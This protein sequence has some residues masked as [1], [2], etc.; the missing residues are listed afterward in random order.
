MPKITKHAEFLDTLRGMVTKEGQTKEGNAGTASGVPCTDTHPEKV[1]ESTEHVNK[2]EQGHPEKNPQDFKQEK[3]KDGPLHG[4]KGEDQTA[5]EKAAE[6]TAC[7]CGKTP[8]VCSK[9]KAAEATPLAGAAQVPDT[10]APAVAKDA[11]NTVSQT[12]AKTAEDNTENLKLA[13]LGEK[14][15]A[16]IKEANEKTASKAG[17]AS[18]VP[19][20]DTKPA[21][22]PASTDHVNKN[23]E[24]RPEHN[25]QEFKQE[26]GKEG[27]LHGQ[28][29]AAVKDVAKTGAAQEDIDKQASFELG[30][31]FC[32]SFLQTKVASQ[33][34]MYKEA[35]RRDFETL[36]AQA[37]DELDKQQKQAQQN[38]YY[39]ANT[40]QARPQTKQAAALYDEQYAEKQAEEAGA[41]AFYGMM[42]QA[43]EEYQAEQIKLAFEQQVAAINAEKDAALKKAAELEAALKDKEASLQKKAE[44]EKRAQEFHTWGNYVVDQVMTRLQSEAAR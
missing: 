36:I 4:K 10:K 21:S 30:R 14:L 44:E 9:E 18:G 38:Q 22:M 32:R 28:P 16:A 34:D 24:G 7:K 26:K 11:P 5:E 13:E 39:Q 17:T 25:P 1:P 37:A 15:L 41:Q 20:H 8:C 29:A 27:P 2:N 23:K 35:G 6:K 31:Q 40:P 12:A 3:G 43:Q 19:G 42:K 33:A